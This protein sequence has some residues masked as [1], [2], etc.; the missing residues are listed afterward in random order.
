M[1]DWQVNLFSTE[2]PFLWERNYVLCCAS[3][4]LR[5]CTV[6]TSSKSEVLV[7][8]VSEKLSQVVGDGQIN[9]FS[10]ELPF[11]WERN[12]V[13]C[14]ASLQL[15]LC[16]LCPGSKSEALVGFVSKKLFQVVGDL[17]VN[18]FGTELLF[19]FMGRYFLLCWSSLWL[20]LCTLCP[21]SKSEA[22]VGFVAEKL[23]QVVGDL[24]VNFFGTEL[25]FFMGKRFCV[26]LL[27]FVTLVLYSVD[28]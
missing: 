1:G 23:S 11:L 12:Y 17:P 9:L 6:C 25:L 21:G 28:P 27:Q 16:T 20:R 13:L 4:W 5:L 10:T 2:L 24:Q 3:L 22:L 7:G 18:F 19:N 15:W 14:C 26:L 8:F